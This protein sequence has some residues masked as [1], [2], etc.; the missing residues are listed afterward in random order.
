MSFRG[1]QLEATVISAGGQD[2]VI[3]AVGDR[4][5]STAARI[6]SQQK[7]DIVPGLEVRELATG[8]RY[9]VLSRPEGHMRHVRI[10]DETR[11]LTPIA[12]TEDV[13]RQNYRFVSA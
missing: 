11:N 4:L 13:L 9:K 10:K 6:H 5:D 3:A 2:F 1:Q 12:V 7:I 8:T